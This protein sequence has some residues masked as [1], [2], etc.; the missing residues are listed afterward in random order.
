MRILLICEYYWPESFAAGIYLRELAEHLVSQG[1]DVTVQT[2]FPH[3]PEGFVWSEYR[4][5]FRMNETK[6][7]VCIRRSFILAFPR[8]IQL[9]IRALTP[10]SFAISSFFSSLFNGKQDI[11]YTLYPIL[12]IGFTSVVLGQI[13][14]CPVILGVKDLSTEGLIQA[15]KL[16][17]GLFQRLLSFFERSLYHFADHLHVPTSNL[18]T[19]LVQNGL[20]PEKITLIPDWADPSAI[21]P[22]PKQNAFRKEHQLEG[23]FVLIYSGNM[24][25][26]CEL[27]TVLHAANLLRN[28]TDVFFLLIG[29]GAKR[30]GLEKQA[31]LAN[32]SNVKFLPFQDRERFPDVLASADFGL[33]TLNSKFT[34]V[35]SQGKMYSIMSSARPLLAVLE[36]EAWGAEWI[37]KYGLGCRVDPGDAE[38]LANQIQVWRSKPDELMA[39]GWRG[40]RLLEEKYTITTCGNSFITL[41][42][43]VHLFKDE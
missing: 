36:K 14:R 15:G 16:K 34:Q 2:A 21:L 9:F 10:L 28:I 24:G 32:L 35:A 20:P 19:Y 5:K 11:I 29:D 4:Q 23:K 8:E 37:D 40:R 41:F 27:E 18:Q 22:L 3:Y 1:H 13:K 26:S 43:K 30:V 39:A 33:I 17:H 38:G 25:Y 12:P 42:E 7:G 6:N 31:I